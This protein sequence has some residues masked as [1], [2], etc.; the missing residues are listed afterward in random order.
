M[1]EGKH[2]ISTISR[3]DQERR[4]MPVKYITS[5][6]IPSLLKFLKTFGLAL[7]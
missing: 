3:Y 5:H 2:L 1:G 4:Y 7:E 6:L